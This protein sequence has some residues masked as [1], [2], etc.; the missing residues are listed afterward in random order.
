M[1]ESIDIVILGSF[2][3]LGASKLSAKSSNM[4]NCVHLCPPVWSGVSLAILVGTTLRV[5]NA[6]KEQPQKAEMSKICKIC[7]VQTSKS[8]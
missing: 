1:S 5:W 8:S 2:C 6:Q 3:L 4:L 7:K